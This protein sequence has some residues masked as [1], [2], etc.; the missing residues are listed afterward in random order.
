M[1]GPLVV[2]CAAHVQQFSPTQKCA[3]PNPDRTNDHDDGLHGQAIHSSVV[4]VDGLRTAVSTSL[5]YGSR[6]PSRQTQDDSRDS[7]RVRDHAFFETSNFVN[8]RSNRKYRTSNWSSTLSQS[9]SAGYTSDRL[10]WCDVCCGERI[11]GAACATKNSNVTV[12]RNLP[13]KI[14]SRHVYGRQPIFPVP[15]RRE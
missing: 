11:R 13:G 1:R 12:S 9:G 6:S 5:W 15:T 4:M 8:M 10:L 14:F 3:C 2:V 7:R